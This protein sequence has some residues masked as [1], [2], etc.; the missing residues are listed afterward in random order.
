MISQTNSMKKNNN[1]LLEKIGKELPF[2]VPENYFEQFASK[3]EEQISNKHVHASRF[4]KPWMY[5]AAMFVGILV[6]GQIFYTVNQNN[7]LKAADNYESYVLSQVDE[8]SLMD[9][10]ADNQ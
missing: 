7:A 3:F 1:I 10:Y 8:T 4:I 2:G 5:M 6:I 9:Y